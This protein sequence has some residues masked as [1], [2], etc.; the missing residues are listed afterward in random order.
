MIN[1]NIGK[2]IVKFAM[3]C[4]LARIIQNLYPL[5]DSLVVGKALDIKSLSAIGISASLYALFNDTFI[6]LVS[7]FAI[8]TSKKFGAGDKKG[9]NLTFYNSFV[10]K[11]ITIKLIFGKFP[12]IVLDYITLELD[13]TD[14]FPY[15]L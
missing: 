4:I 14:Y 10:Y 2:S 11:I 12:L 5:I 13:I 1:G 3:P 15:Q 6:G 8:I 7:G 9:A